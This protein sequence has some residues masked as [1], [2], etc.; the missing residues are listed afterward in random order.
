MK[1]EQNILQ[2]I[3][4]GRTDGNLYFLPAGQLERKVYV[5][6]NKVL[7]LLGGKW[8]KKLKAHLFESP[9]DD[10][11]SNVIAT[12][13]VTNHNKE[14]QFFET[15]YEIADQIVSLAEIKPSSEIL[16]PSAG[17]GRIIKSV[18]KVFSYPRLSF[19]EIDMKNIE[20]LSA[21]NAGTCVAYDFMMYNPAISNY[22]RIVM[23]P[24]FSNQQDIDHVT[25]ALKFLSDDGILVSVMSPAIKFRTNR[26]TNEF[27]A[28]LKT[29]RSH[30]IIDLPENSFKESGTTIKTVILKVRK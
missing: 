20:Y 15:P 30:E 9:I 28:L 23:N 10:V 12:G 3:D 1:I 13:E 16:E 8:N 26:K 17:R 29:F 18:L 5:D 2:I 22:D 27:N 14:L 19:C 6:V 21:L 7:E 11:I 24:P 25:H 4:A